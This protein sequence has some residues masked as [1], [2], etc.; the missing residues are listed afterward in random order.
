MRNSVRSVSYLNY[1]IPLFLIPVF[2]IFG[3]F[4][5]PTLNV[6]FGQ[7]WGI[8]GGYACAVI[9]LIL[10]ISHR[11]AIEPWNRTQIALFV[12]MAAA[13]LFQ[14]V[15]T[16]TDG[17]AF[18][19][20]AFLLPFAL[21]LILVKR[22]TKEMLDQSFLWF[23]YG[24]VSISML[25]LVFGSVGIGPDGFDAADSGWSRI[26]LL[27]DLL[28]VTTRWAGPFGSVNYAAPVGGLLILAGLT[29]RGGNRWVITLGGLVVIVLSQGRTSLF[30][31]LFSIVII[32][33]YLP[34]IRSLRNYR[35]I[36][37]LAVGGILALAV[38]YIVVRDPTLAGRT[39][40]WRNFFDL[41]SANP[42]LGIGT[43]GLEGYIAAG[44]PDSDVILFS[45][46]HNVVLDIA[47]RYGI[48]L[49]IATIA[50][51]SLAILISWRYRNEDAGHSLALMT[52][53]VIAGLA[54]SIYDWQY[55]GIYLI[56]ITYVATL[57]NSSSIRQ[58][59][60]V[61]VT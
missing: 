8:I 10:W 17:S 33:I 34:P 12:L 26:P 45:H 52:F 19:Y 28:G 23:L 15:S 6:L 47:V 1:L 56:V 11:T 43:S 35:L 53:V 44:L 3:N 48:I 13:W 22:P 4:T 55:F 31:L 49:V 29:L 37:G 27:S 24:L 25:A 61:S 2:V 57:P 18:N 21:I 42:L 40:I 46:G 32:F 14:S 5:A 38:S 30:A 36:A 9:A 50:I 58:S 59:Q 16:H 51:L 39:P 20:T 54:E 41:F 60:H 7:N